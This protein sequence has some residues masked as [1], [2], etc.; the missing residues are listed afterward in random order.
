MLI[1]RLVFLH[2]IILYNALWVDIVLCMMDFVV[3]SALLPSCVDIFHY[4]QYYRRRREEPEQGGPFPFTHNFRKQETAT[5]KWNGRIQ[6]LYGFV[7][8]IEDYGYT[9]THKVIPYWDVIF[10]TLELL[11]A[12]IS[13]MFFSYFKHWSVL[14][15]PLEHIWTF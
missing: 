14:S 5:R 8:T 3:C 10:V 4:V 6:N 2:L 12:A 11:W 9:Y 1:C 7:G 15:F 13:R